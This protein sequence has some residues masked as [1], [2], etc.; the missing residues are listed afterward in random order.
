MSKLNPF[1]HIDIEVNNIEKGIDFYSKLLPELGF[2]KTYHT[3][4]WKVFATEGELP[5]AAYFAF[6]ENPDHKPNNN[7]L[8]FWASSPTEV[9]R[10]A[11]IVKIIGGKITDGPKHY[12]ISETYYAFYFQ[13]PFGNKFEI[14]HRLS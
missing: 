9:D 8:G 4:K 7:T 3:D 2:T 14:Y 5:S 12:N 6:A 1:G 11:S 13:D 10:I